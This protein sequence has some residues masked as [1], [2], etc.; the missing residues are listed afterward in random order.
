MLLILEG[1]T[2]LP[3]DSEAFKEIAEQGYTVPPAI[4][5][6]PFY[7]RF[8]WTSAAYDETPAEELEALRQIMSI[9]DEWRKRSKE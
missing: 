6:F 5:R 9:V 3:P 2:A 1:L 8:H 4:E 7:E